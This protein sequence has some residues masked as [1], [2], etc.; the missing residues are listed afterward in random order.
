MKIGISAIGYNCKEHLDKV[1]RPWIDY[2][3]SN[4]GQLFISIV[5]GV[6]PE[7]YQIGDC[8]IFSEDGTIESLQEYK[9][10]GEIDF[11]QVLSEPTYE[12]DIRNYTLKNLFK[13]DIDLLW[14]LDL[15]DEIYD[16]KEILRIL[17][18]IDKNKEVDWFKINFKNYIIKPGCYI[19][20]FIAP[21]IWRTKIYGG[22]QGFYYDNDIIYNDNRKAVEL[23]NL[24]IP[25]EI[26]FPKHY[27]WIGSPEYL[28]RKIEFQR[29]H[30]T[31]CSYCW[32][33]AKN[34]LDFDMNY[35]IMNGKSIP[36]VYHD[37]ENE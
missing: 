6:F 1:I 29:R 26:A 9:N 31:H 28:K 33:E 7:V 37:N 12:K 27:S 11:F 30:Y 14:L 15:Q 20:D 5:H 8:P 13:H 16:P 22:I 3:K 18:F 24:I 21:R 35:Y 19:D 2:K 23:P 4:P 10:L 34:S 32:N 36:K 17:D 25:R